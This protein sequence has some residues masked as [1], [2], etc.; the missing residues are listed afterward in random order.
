M[1]PSSDRAR[2]RRRLSTIDD[3]REEYTHERYTHTHTRDT[4]ATHTHTHGKSRVLSVVLYFYMGILFGIYELFRHIYNMTVHIAQTS[5]P[6]QPNASLTLRDDDD[7]DRVA[8]APDDERSISITHDATT[9]S[10]SRDGDEY[11]N[12]DDDDDDDDASTSSSSS[13]AS[14]ASHHATKRRGRDDAR[15]SRARGRVDV[16]RRATAVRKRPRARAQR[17]HR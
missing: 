1:M 17:G 7:R 8:H 14:K 11:F 10:T 6:S 12:D 15:A 5:V 3:R 4:R 16:G 2:E 9:V 13:K